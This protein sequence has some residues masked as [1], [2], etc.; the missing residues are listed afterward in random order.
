M[1]EIFGNHENINPEFLIDSTG[2]HYININESSVQRKK[3]AKLNN[4]ELAYIESIAAISESKMIS[5]ETQIKLE[6]ERIE[7]EKFKENGKIELEKFKYKLEI[8]TSYELKIKEMKLKLKEME[9]KC[10]GSE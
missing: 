6:Q 5:A 4:N 9:V 3:K 1:N 10:K 7:L 8:K 2:K